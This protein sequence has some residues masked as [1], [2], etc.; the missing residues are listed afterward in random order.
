M[1][2]VLC[3]RL[4]YQVKQRIEDPQCGVQVSGRAPTY[5]GTNMSDFDEREFQL[6]E[7]HIKLLQRAYVNWEDCE[8]GAPAIGCK[9]PYGNSW[10][11]GDVVEILEIEHPLY[12]TPDYDTWET[13][14]FDRVMKLHYETQDAL[15]IILETRSF[16]PGLYR[17][18]KD[19]YM[20]G[21]QLCHQT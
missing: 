7:A 5:E 6:T 13:E 8:T 9:R 17:K 4:A 19:K 12:G 16:V 14:N 15:Q 18:S 11:F 21:W 10:V 20:R 3:A 2:R 1:W